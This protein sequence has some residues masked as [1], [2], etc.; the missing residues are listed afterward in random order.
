MEN[1]GM[2][3]IQ[4]GPGRA[5][6]LLLALFL[7]CAGPVWAA[8]ISYE[9]EIG[10]PGMVSGSVGGYGWTDRDASQVDFWY[11]NIGPGGLYVD[12]WAERGDIALDPVF[13]LYSGT[14]T[15]DESEFLNVQGFGGM[16]LIAWAD[17]EIDVPGSPFGDPMID[18]LFLDEGVYTI[19]MGG[20]FS[21]G[22][23]PYNYDL[24]I[25]YVTPVPAPAAAWLL[26]SALLGLAGL[27][28]RKHS[29]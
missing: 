20:F 6:Q 22:A 19:A 27:A 4:N 16:D 18:G 15:A 17:D 5:Q 21:D 3:P 29:A 28:R 10:V 7:A 9:G 14:T 8:P 23:G 26:G 2:Q 11:F 13:S 25:N 24:F 1:S 12:I